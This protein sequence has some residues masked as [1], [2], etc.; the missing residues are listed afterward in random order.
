[1]KRKQREG[2][3]IYDF[4]TLVFEH[5]LERENSTLRYAKED[6]TA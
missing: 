1:M 4:S 5:L 6:R 2:L 3:C